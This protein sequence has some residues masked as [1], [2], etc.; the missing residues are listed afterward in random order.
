[1]PIDPSSVIGIPPR[2]NLVGGVAL[3]THSV[4]GCMSATRII[5]VDSDDAVIVNII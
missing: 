5:A 1:M 2:R 3:N 4:N